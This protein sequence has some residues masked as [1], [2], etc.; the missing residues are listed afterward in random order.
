MT[1]VKKINKKL[2]DKRIMPTADKKII[3]ALKELSASD[4]LAMHMPGHKR[5]TEIAEYLKLLGAEYDITEIDGFDDLFDARGILARSMERASAIWASKKTYYLVNGS[6]CGI[7]AG[8]R[9]AAGCGG[10]AIMARNCHKS[11]YNALEICGLEASFVIPLTDAESGIQASLSPEDIESALISNPDAA[12]IIL[13]SPTYEGVISDIAAICEIAHKRGVPVLVDEAHGAHLGFSEYFSG[14]AVRAGADIVIQSLHKTLPSLTQT[15]VAHLNGDI[16]NPIEFERQLAVFETSSPSYLLM[17]SIDGCVRLMEEKG[18][19]LFDDWEQAL[20]RFYELT[21]DLKNLK[22]LMHGVRSS[23]KHPNIFC[24]DRG[25]ILISTRDAD[26][27]GIGLM[28][29]LRRDYAVELEMANKSYALAMTGLGEREENL[30]R[31][32]RALLE[33]DAKLTSAKGKTDE[34]HPDIPRKICTAAEAINSEKTCVLLENSEGMICAEYVFAYPPGIPL[35]IPGEEI[36]GELILEI[37]EL[38][39]CGVGLKSTFKTAPERIYTVKN[40]LL[41][42]QDS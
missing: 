20:G 10:K 35:I 32:G 25:K 33:I 5:N 1:L 6:T 9:A 39:K 21:S 38:A 30:I 15:A 22:I 41:K 29:S 11:V 18:K 37:G 2:K 14:G 27:S 19:R 40:R 24:F 7:L 17:A 36:S 12:L 4:V 16:V 23:D 3:E 31:L 42:M 34:K 28:D 26:I 13:T 8:V